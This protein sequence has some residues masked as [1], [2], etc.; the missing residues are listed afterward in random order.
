MFVVHYRLVRVAAA[1]SAS[2]ALHA[3][4]SCGTICQR[5]RC[6]RRPAATSRCGPCAY[7]VGIDGRQLAPPARP[8]VGA[9]I[10]NAA[11]EAEQDLLAARAR[12]PVRLTDDD[13]AWLSHAGADI[14]AVFHAPSTTARNASSRCVRSCPRSLSPRCHKANGRAAD[15]LARR[16]VHRPRDGAEQDW[17]AFPRHRRGHR[18]AGTAAGRALRRHHHRADPVPAAPPHRH[19]VAVHQKPCAVA[20]GLPRHPRPPASRKRRTRRR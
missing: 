15:H 7:S 20:A 12:R 14:R 11:A 1:S 6:E 19:R 17:R 3:R 5:R 13:L 8:G 4:R 9:A 18:R 10:A 16:R 2:P